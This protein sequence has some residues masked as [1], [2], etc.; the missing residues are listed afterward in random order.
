[1][2]SIET[3]PQLRQFSYE[4][5]A[6]IRDY[7]P[8]FRVTFG[9]YC[10]EAHV[11]PRLPISTELY[12]EKLYLAMFSQSPSSNTQL[13]EQTIR[14]FVTD[15]VD[16]ESVL[17]KTWMHMINDF[18]DVL[19]DTSSST[20]ALLELVHWIDHLSLALYHT[21]FH[22]S[23]ETTREQ[24][25]WTTD[26]QHRSMELAEGFARLLEQPAKQ[27]EL[28]AGNPVEPTLNGRCYFRGVE[29]VLKADLLSARRERIRC[30]LEPR[31]CAIAS[32]SNH[33]LI[34][35]PN[36]EGQI[37]AQI[38]AVDMKAHEVALN[39]FESIPKGEDRRHE[40]RVEPAVP[41][42]VR[43]LHAGGQVRATVVDISE[44]AVALYVRNSGVDLENHID[45][46]F[47]LPCPT[48]IGCEI[49][50]ETEG[51]VSDIRLDK[52]RDPRAHVLVVNFESDT[53]THADLSNY[54]AH[55]Q[56]VILKEIRHIMEGDTT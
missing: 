53:S 39:R 48:G 51:V 44:H 18:V 37:L 36:S 31:Y 47:T 27:G 46:K 32:R 25:K 5:A 43:M 56:S 28:S 41:V 23:Q 7:L 50:I 19:E 54:V 49:E 38:M 1:M 20:Q 3:A 45:L 24:D 15:T 52:R 21:Y 2:A 11:T 10:N 16:A 55:R 33:L 9:G 26:H 34:D 14:E 30:R 8:S 4:C 42:D 35:C 13:L 40:V 29:M 22:I 6:F 12:A 17:L